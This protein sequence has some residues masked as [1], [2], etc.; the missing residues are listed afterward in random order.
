VNDGTNNRRAGLF[1]DQT[2]GYWG[3]TSR[4]SSGVVP[5]I[6]HQNGAIQLQLS[7]SG[8]ATLYNNLLFGT[9]ATYDVGASGANR[10]RDLYLSR[11]IVNGGTINAGGAISSGG[12]I[13][14]GATNAFTWSGRSIVRSGADGQIT[15]LN[16]AETGFTRLNFGG[17]T[18][19]EVSLKRNG[20]GLQ[21]RK[22]DDSAMGSFEAAGADFYG[23]IRALTDASAITLGAATDVLLYRD[24]AN[25][26]ALRNGVNGQIFR[27]YNTTDGGANYERALIGWSGNILLIGTG[28]GGTGAQRQ[29]DFITAG[30]SRWTLTNTGNLIAAADNTYDIGASGANRPRSVY[31]GGTIYSGNGYHLIGSGRVEWGGRSIIQSPADGVLALYNNALTGFTGIKLGGVTSAF[32]YIKVNGAEAQFRLADDSG[33]TKV[34]GQLKTHANA[35]AETPTATHTLTLYDAAGTAYRVLCCV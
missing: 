26:L 31:T 16:Q 24:A 8:V 5:F 32:P 3:L 13:A 22:G 10:A 1:V 9:D 27:V 34:Q 18:V 20:A 4:A 12:S 11:N 7:T 25:I 17:A 14:A 33:F 28:S 19:A 15:L 30:T 35:V 6:I 23:N 29:M 21:V 2:N